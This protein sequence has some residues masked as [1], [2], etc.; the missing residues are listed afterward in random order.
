M[1]NKVLRI[2][3]L[4][5]TFLWPG[6]SFADEK[7][8]NDLLANKTVNPFSTNQAVW[9]DYHGWYYNNSVWETTSFLGVPANKSVSDMWNYQEIISELQPSIVIEFGTL[10]G[11]SA[12]F[13]S[14]IARLVN[15]SAVVLSVD[16]DHR[17]TYDR[18]KQDPHIEL[19]TCFSTDPKVVAR[20]IEL[21]GQHPG[22]VFAI[23]DSDHHKSNVL[24]EMELL[25]PLLKRGDYLVVEDGNVNGHPVLKEFGEGPY[26]AILEYFKRYPEDYEKDTAREEKFGFTFAVSG[27]LKRC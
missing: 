17:S 8:A 13:F 23:L 22:P 18:V 10:Y 2:I 9:D 5:F 6:K 14:T 12:L 27:F 25:R 26:E 21:R 15:P 1:F 19:L 11:G 20:I 16:I 3:F 24:N 7:T 4:I